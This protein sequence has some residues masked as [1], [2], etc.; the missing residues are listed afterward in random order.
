MLF[1]RFPRRPILGPLSDTLF[2]TFSSLGF[3]TFFDGRQLETFLAGA[4]YREFR[5]FRRI[6]T[7]F[8]GKTHRNPSYFVSVVCA[9]YDGFLCVF[10]RT[11]V[12]I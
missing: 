1:R 6:L 5:E 11:V 8:L 10:P 7:N 3:G 4:L 9:N 2:R 12:R